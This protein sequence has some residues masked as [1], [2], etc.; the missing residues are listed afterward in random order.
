MCV[1]L[2][3][4]L[5]G[6]FLSFFVVKNAVLPVFDIRHEHETK[7]DKIC[8]LSNRS[9]SMMSFKRSVTGL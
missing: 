5:F 4:C 6:F 3:F 2:L 9:R 7:E 8:S 1:F